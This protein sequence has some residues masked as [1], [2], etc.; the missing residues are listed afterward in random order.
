MTAKCR[1]DYRGEAVEQ[2]SR[3]R[4][5]SPRRRPRAAFDRR[6]VAGTGP[7][8]QPARLAGRADPIVARD[9]GGDLGGGRLA[10]AATMIEPAGPG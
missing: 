10:D 9:L 4:L 7:A 2:Q 5:S 3:V 1:V 6:I 8:L